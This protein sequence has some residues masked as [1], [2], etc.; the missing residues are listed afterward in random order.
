MCDAPH[1]TGD[2]KGIVTLD[3][4]NRGYACSDQ[5]ANLI[6]ASLVA[7]IN[8]PMTQS[9]MESKFRELFDRVAA[10]E[11]IVGVNA[12]SSAAA[13][14]AA[15]SFTFPQL[16]TRAI[17]VMT[18]RATST[19]PSLIS[20]IQQ[21]VPTEEVREV[22]LLSDLVPNQRVIL[23][24]YASTPRVPSAATITD[25]I[26]DVS[27]VTGTKPLLA[28]GRMFSVSS[29]RWAAIDLIPAQNYDG[30][31]E[32]LIA[33]STSGGFKQWLGAPPSA[34]QIRGSS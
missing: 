8:A 15:P 5:C 13:A 16:P 10:I 21:L 32:F 11:R 29:E 12:P 14:A 22:S 1:C 31:I 2:A 19:S 24:V 6:A 7:P 26:R 28:V 30:S 3:G 33:S 18:T 17:A 4:V 34:G 9:E 25:I 23:V 20:A 27:R